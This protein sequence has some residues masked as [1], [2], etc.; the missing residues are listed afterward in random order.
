MAFGQSDRMD[1]QSDWVNPE[2]T[3]QINEN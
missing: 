3:G 1:M 2:I